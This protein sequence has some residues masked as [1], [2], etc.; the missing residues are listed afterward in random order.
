[1]RLGVAWAETNRLGQARGRLG[2]FADGV[3]NN[4]QQKMGLDISGIHVHDPRIRSLG[5][6]QLSCAMIGL[7]PERVSRQP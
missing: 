2:Q 7:W 1:M 3:A 6:V 4:A 5:V